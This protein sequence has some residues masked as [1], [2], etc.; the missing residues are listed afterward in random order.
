MR[1]LK[2]Y[3]TAQDDM[4]YST[5]ANGLCVLSVTH[6]NL[7]QKHVELKFD[8][9][10]T[11]YEVKSKIYRHSGTKADYQKLML[12]G[13]D[14]EMMYEL[15]DNT[16]MLGYYS[17]ES[18][19]TIHV[20]DLDPHSLSKY[21]GLEDVS[22]VEKYR[23]TDEEYDSRNGTLRQWKR[24][25]LALD[26]NFKYKHPVLYGTEEA[27]ESKDGVSEDFEPPTIESV[28]GMKAGMR[29]QVKPGD[30]RGEVM[31]VGEYQDKAKKG[32]SIPLKARGYWVGVKFDEPVG[33]SDGTNR[34][35]EY[36]KAPPKYG[37]F[38]R[39]DKIEV[40]DFPENLDFSDS[41][42]EI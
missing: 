38:I 34:G 8:L 18:G 12:K 40:G 17:P 37:A 30:R 9:H 15:S 25:Q 14:G 29:C 13:Y 4:Q 19:M 27:P 39:G 35:I 23:M 28:E 31:W 22:L 6:E 20:V 26:P 7:I 3:I 5:L 24:E 32:F 41:D 42:E 2:S 11:I 36:F 16:K 21:G 1:E 10:M 33:K